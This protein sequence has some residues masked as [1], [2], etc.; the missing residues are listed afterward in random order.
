ME[1]EID[2]PEIMWMKPRMRQ[3][4]TINIK[5]LQIK[6]QVSHIMDCNDNGISHNVGYT[7]TQEMHIKLRTPMEK[8]EK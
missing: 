8:T 7:N 3:K 2:K 5:S 4:N 6:K 1:T